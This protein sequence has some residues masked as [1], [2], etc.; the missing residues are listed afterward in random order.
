MN[1]L[2]F[3]FVILSSLLIF[4]CS[5]QTE[6]T[7]SGEIK[8]SGE[9]TPIK[10]FTI[11]AKQWNFEPSVITVNKGDRV[12]I[13]IT[14]ADVAHGFA[15]SDYGVNKRIDAGKTEVVEFTADKTGTFTYRCSVPCG[16]GH[17][18]MGGT[19]IVE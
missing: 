10:E 16:S 15:I 6:T 14:S 1:K 19:L 2:N 5:Q 3:I 4:G 7:Q 11:T 18:T 8:D 13:T 9:E 12:K 17:S